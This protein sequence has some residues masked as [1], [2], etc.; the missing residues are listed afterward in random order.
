MC[1][2]MQYNNEVDNSCVDCPSVDYCRYCGLND[3]GIA[4]CNECEA[5]FELDSS[6]G[7]YVSCGCN[8]TT[9]LTD[10]SSCQLCADYAVTCA[11]SSGDA[12]SC[13]STFTL[14]SG[15]CACASDQFL[16][17]SD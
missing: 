2:T 1:P 11:D 10:A 14:T 12:T 6:S 15:V 13:L 8:S 16:D 5:T 9:F 7:A 4:V 3:A 17:A